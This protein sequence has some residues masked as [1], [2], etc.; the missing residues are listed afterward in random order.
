[1]F[2]TPTY[3]TFSQSFA[4]KKPPNGWLFYWRRKEFERA[5]PVHTLVQKYAG[6]S[7][8]LARGRIHVHTAAS[9][10]DVDGCT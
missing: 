2:L 5:A 9:R 8:F 1:M 10:R 3:A 7:M 4:I 6:E